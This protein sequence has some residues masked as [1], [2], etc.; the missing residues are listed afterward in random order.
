MA[1]RGKR[2]KSRGPRFPRRTWEAGQ[3]P[4]VEKPKKGGGYD[5][6]REKRQDEE[7]IT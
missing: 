5:R 2:K 3:K 7:E 1:S 4:R 6:T